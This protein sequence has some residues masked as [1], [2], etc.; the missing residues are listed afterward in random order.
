MSRD[1]L[2]DVFGKPID[3]GTPGNVLPRDAHCCHCL[4]LGWAFEEIDASY[5]SA[6]AG[7]THFTRLDGTVDTNVP[8]VLTIGPMLRRV[9][10]VAANPLGGGP[11]PEPRKVF[12]C[13]H[14]DDDGLCKIYERRPAMC[15]EYPL[16]L[17]GRRCQY[18]SCQST[19]CKFRPQMAAQT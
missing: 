9:G 7:G 17:K 14:I 18:L 5:R 16:N 8:D 1:V 6:A 10:V 12:R 3:F 15:R 4:A 13:V 19:V 2:L 11:F